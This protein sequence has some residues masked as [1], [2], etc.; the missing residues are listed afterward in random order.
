[1]WPRVR[2]RAR[3]ALWSLVGPPALAA[4]V[5]WTNR[6]L[7]APW[8]AR[9]AHTSVV[10]AAGAIYV[11]GGEGGFDGTDNYADVWAS[12]DGGADPTRAWWSGGTRGGYYRGYAKVVR[13]TMWVPWVTIGY[14][15]VLEG[16]YRG[17]RG[18]SCSI[19][20]RGVPRMPSGLLGGYLGVAKG[21]SRSTLG[22]YSRGY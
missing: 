7:S 19:D 6:T 17:A 8:E 5:T 13:D 16:Y 22:G 11:I 2:P 15:E 20:T 3:V 10:D 21:F 14:Y 4:G 1:M 9:A 12:T 18:A